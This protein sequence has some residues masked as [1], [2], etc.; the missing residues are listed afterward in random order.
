MRAPP[1][2]LKEATINGRRS[3]IWTLEAKDCAEF[4]AHQ[5]ARVGI[6]AAHVPY[7][8]V[9]LSPSGSFFMAS[10]EGQGKMLLEG[11]WQTVMPGTLCL[12]PPRILNALSAVRGQRW[13]FAWVRYD[14]PAAI[15]PLVGAASPLRAKEGAEQLGRAVAGLRAA[16]TGRRDPTEIHHWV[17]LAH[18]LCLRSA[19]PWQG[20]SRIGSLWDAV[21]RDL[22]RTWKLPMLAH[23]CHMSGEHLR[24]LCLREL[25]RTPMEHVTYI[26]I[27][28]A[29][30]LL[31]TNSEKLEVVAA[32]VGYHS[33]DVFTRAFTRCVGIPPS[34]FRARSLPGGAPSASVV[35]SK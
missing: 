28:R 14:E 26:R 24:R 8:R 7:R 27:Q 13:V 3:R 29:R 2:P 6:D 19:R 10:L 25:G 1:A 12:A 34:D 30:E 17:N 5:I 18:R 9:R 33:A 4:A 35:R 15:K 31:E 20:D 23:H 32:Q 16:W 21:L 11:Q 22:T